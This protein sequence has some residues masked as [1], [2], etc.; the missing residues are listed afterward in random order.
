MIKEDQ[1]KQ[2]IFFSVIFI[3]FFIFSYCTYYLTLKK[4][5]N[6]VLISFFSTLLFTASVIGLYFGIL[7]VQTKDNYTRLLTIPKAVYCKNSTRGIPSGK[8][9]GKNNFLGKSIK[10]RQNI[11]ECQKFISSE[12]GRDEVEQVSCGIA[13]PD[14]PNQIIMGRKLPQAAKN[15]AAVFTPLSDSAWLNAR[16]E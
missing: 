11:P 1:K 12:V 9:T 10:T 2:I 6:G 14:I 15:A 8:Y 7:Q 5:Y 16:C 3:L 4:N 13:I